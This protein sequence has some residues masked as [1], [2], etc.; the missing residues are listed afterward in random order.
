[1]TVHS[2]S[3]RRV[4]TAPLLVVAVAL[5]DSGGVPLAHPQILQDFGADVSTVAWVLTAFNLVLA[6]VAVPAARVCLRGDP[7]VATASGLVIFAA[8][9]AGCAFAPSLGVLIA[10]RAVQAVGGALVI[11]GGLELLVAATGA[12][13]AGARLWAA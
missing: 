9:T 10:A 1:M 13:R 7:A 12:E 4:A 11:V 8:G 2:P 5:G 3:R 6:L